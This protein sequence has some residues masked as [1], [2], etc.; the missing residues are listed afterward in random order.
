MATPLT[1]PLV[2]GNRH[3]FASIT[4][5]AADT[6]FIGFTSIEYSRERDRELVYGNHPDPLGKTLGQNSY[7]ATLEM[8]RAEWDLLRA[9]LGEGYGDKFFDVYV[10][11]GA[12]GFD[13][14]TDEILGCTMDTS[15]AGGSVGPDALV[16]SVELNP[17]KI[18][19]AGV[20]DLSEP[21][22]P[23]SDG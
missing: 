16:V 3:N 19:F 10:T 13:T 20:D 2:N 1:V 17:I 22:R 21:L 8:L 7:S 15:E 18:L 23:P 6:K 11:Y 14:V 9:T 5:K 12:K 4:L